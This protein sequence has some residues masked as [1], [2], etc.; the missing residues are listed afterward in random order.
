MSA[1]RPSNHRQGTNPQPQHRSVPIPPRYPP[2]RTHP[3][4]SRTLRTNLPARSGLSVRVLLHH[5]ATLCARQRGA[6]ACPC[7]TS[8]LA[9]LRHQSQYTRIP[10]RAACRCACP[11]MR[12]DSPRH[13]VDRTAPAPRSLQ[14]RGV[15]HPDCCTRTDRCRHRDVPR[16]CPQ[17][18]AP[19]AS[20]PVKGRRRSVVPLF[21]KLLRREVHNTRRVTVFGPSETNFR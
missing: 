1:R 21:A 10:I 14:C 4:G 2:C 19:S 9:S 6:T 13:R 3:R 5:V 18:K 20:R 15:H 12:R 17:D 11:S 7:C 16:P 8:Q